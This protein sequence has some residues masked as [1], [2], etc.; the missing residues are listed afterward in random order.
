MVPQ[1]GSCTDCTATWAR[2]SPTPAPGEATNPAALLPGK[3]AIV[4][5][6]PPTTVGVGGVRAGVTDTLASRVNR[7]SLH[8][9]FR[10]LPALGTHALRSDLGRPQSGC[11]LRGAAPSSGSISEIWAW[12]PVTGKRAWGK[13]GSLGTLTGLRTADGRELGFERL[14]SFNH[15]QLTL[16]AFVSRWAGSP[17][18]WVFLR[19][20]VRPW[21]CPCPTPLPLRSGGTPA[22]S[23]GSQHPCAAHAGDGPPPHRNTLLRR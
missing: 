19:G 10:A 8:P 22:Y 9:T 21:S 15:N 23:S 6:V 2:V 1:K 7:P 20:R 3:G 5:G 18:R 12:R 17:G 11:H 13:L 4:P 16:P 14:I